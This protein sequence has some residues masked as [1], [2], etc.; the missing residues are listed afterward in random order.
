MLNLVQHLGDPGSGPGMTKVLARKQVPGPQKPWAAVLARR[1]LPPPPQLSVSLLNGH[2]TS[3]SRA[4][5]SV[6]AQET[7][8]CFGYCP[9]QT[10]L[11]A[12]LALNQRKIA[13]AVPITTTACAKFDHTPRRCQPIGHGDPGSGPGMTK[14][15]ARDDEGGPGMTKVLARHDGRAPSC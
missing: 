9:K 13:Q 7:P 6:S 1:Q 10:H 11:F 15:R 14:V 3:L 5:F 12:R 2:A 4:R 8:D